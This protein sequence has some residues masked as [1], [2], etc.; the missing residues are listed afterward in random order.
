[1]VEGREITIID[2]MPWWSSLCQLVF[3]AEFDAA[4]KGRGEEKRTSRLP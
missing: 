3:C 2:G 1:M 4:G